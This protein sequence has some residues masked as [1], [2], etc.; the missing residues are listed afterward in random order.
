MDVTD[1]IEKARKTLDKMYSVSVLLYDKVC[2]EKG[3][4]S[5]DAGKALGAMRITTESR[6]LFYALFDLELKDDEDS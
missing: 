4:G 5:Y 1:K 2:R 3:S 6:I